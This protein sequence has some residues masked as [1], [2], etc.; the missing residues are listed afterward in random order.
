MVS[1][2][3]LLYRKPPIKYFGFTHDMT[4]CQFIFVQSNWHDHYEP[5]TLAY[6][7]VLIC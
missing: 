3:W 2:V 1:G 7:L 6:F 5:A 4:C